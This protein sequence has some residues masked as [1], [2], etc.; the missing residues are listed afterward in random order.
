MGLLEH[1]QKSF[2]IPKVCLAFTQDSRKE[3]FGIGKQYR[4]SPSRRLKSRCDLGEFARIRHLRRAESPCTAPVRHRK[5]T[6]PPRRGAAAHQDITV[7]NTA[8]AQHGSTAAQR[9]SPLPHRRIGTTS[10]MPHSDRPN[11]SHRAWKPQ[12]KHPPASCTCARE[13]HAC[14]PSSHAHA[15]ASTWSSSAMN[16]S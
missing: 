7:V 3:T 15:S 11:S 16:S 13:P 12:V 8:P 2:P 4:D 5:P 14:P 10:H 6:A 1:F 9:L